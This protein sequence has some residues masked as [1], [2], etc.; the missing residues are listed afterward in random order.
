MNIPEQ[1]VPPNTAIWA[2]GKASGKT[3]RLLRMLIEAWRTNPGSTKVLRIEV[4]SGEE[5]NL[6]DA[7]AAAHEK[8]ARYKEALKAQVVW[9]A[10]CNE[11]AFSNMEGADEKEFLYWQNW[12]NETA[13][14]MKQ[15][16]E[17]L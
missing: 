13:D 12:L 6:K 4:L 2:T 8:S 15:I 5:M 11:A 3:A 16:R 1:K 14:R 7:L 10:K 9:L 17:A